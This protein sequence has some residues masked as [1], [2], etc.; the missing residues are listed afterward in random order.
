MSACE[1]L[2]WLSYRTRHI[3]AP[4]RGRYWHT[5]GLSKSSLPRGISSNRVPSLP[6]S[7]PPPW[8]GPPWAAGSAGSRVRGLGRGSCHPP[9]A[10]ISDR[11]WGPR[12]SATPTAVLY[13]LFKII[14][15]LFQVRSGQVGFQHYYRCKDTRFRAFGNPYLMAG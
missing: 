10:S 5:D 9:S 6:F 4:D 3:H 14:Y 8:L 13:D 11:R 7:S 12:R 1:D 15:A 2:R